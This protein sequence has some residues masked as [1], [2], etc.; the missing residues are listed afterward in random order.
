MREHKTDKKTR[1]ADN[2]LPG[3][4]PVLEALRG[5]DAGIDCVYIDGGRKSQEIEELFRL[6][7]E[8]GVKFRVVSGDELNR[9]FDGNH[10]GVLA[11]LFAPGFVELDDLLERLPAAPLPVLLALDQI[12]DPGNVGTMARTLYA[13]GGA[14]L[15]TT[16]DR[17]AYLGGAARKA[18][19]GALTR[20][21]VCQAVN[22][23][24]TLDACEEQGI[25][26]YGTGLGPDSVDI[27]DLKP[28]FPCALVLGGEE[29]GMRPNVAK[30]CQAMIRIPFGREF[31]S[32]NVAQAAAVILGQFWG[33]KRRG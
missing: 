5:Q 23:A 19:A 13:L 14:G 8:Q 10:Q 25:A 11:R 21:P 29:K 24:R 28:E 6:C 26:I 22:L 17:G 2:L 31:D 1:D 18:S 9:M 30:R 33:A 4:K 3:R 12:Q 7:R 20:L 15:L 16:K 32:L 27:Y